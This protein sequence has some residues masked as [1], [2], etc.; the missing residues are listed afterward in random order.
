MAVCRPSMMRQP[1]VARLA[2]GSNRAHRTTTR[3]R[4]P[5]APALLNLPAGSRVPLTSCTRV[6]EVALHDPVGGSK[7]P[8][9]PPRRDGG[10]H[11]FSAPPFD[12]VWRIFGQKCLKVEIRTHCSI[13]IKS[14]LKWQGDDPR[15]ACSS[16]SAARTRLAVAT[17]SVRQRRVGAAT[18]HAPW[19]RVRAQSV[20][21]TP[22][23]AVPRR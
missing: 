12:A 4:R 10:R 13:R 18:T 22:P 6:D 7:G 5:L 23:T 20:A 1:N 3:P 16:R 8:A 19:P 15:R 11:E 9:P 21:S 17:R 2:P 14:A